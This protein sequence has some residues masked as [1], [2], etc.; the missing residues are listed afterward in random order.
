MARFTVFQKK[1]P[2]PNS[3]GLPFCAAAIW[4]SGSKPKFGFSLCRWYR[5]AN[6]PP[7]LGCDAVE[8]RALFLHPLGV[9]VD[10]A[11][12]AGHDLLLLLARGMI[13]T[14]RDLSVISTLALVMPQ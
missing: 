13:E 2:G 7:Q 4:K 14:F 11:G 6:D 10:L 8:H 3:T 5:L 9:V 12:D 1:K